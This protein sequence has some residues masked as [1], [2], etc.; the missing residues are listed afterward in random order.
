MARLRD[1]YQK[2]LEGSKSYLTAAD[3]KD[4]GENYR[5]RRMRAAIR[6]AEPAWDTDPG[7]NSE[8]PNS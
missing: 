2:E 4:P 3:V 8:T 1:R 6:T 7:S 5:V